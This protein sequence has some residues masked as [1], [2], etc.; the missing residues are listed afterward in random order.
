MS[1]NHNY[2]PD[3]INNQNLPPQPPQGINQNTPN[4]NINHNN[5]INNIN[6]NNNY[7]NNNYNNNNNNNNYSNYNNQ[8]NH[9]LGNEIQQPPN[10]PMIPANNLFSQGEIVQP[11]EG[12]QE[13][14]HLPKI[15]GCLDPLPDLDQNQQWWQKW[16]Q[17]QKLEL[18]NNYRIFQIQKMTNVVNSTV[19]GVIDQSGSMSDCFRWLAKEWNEQIYKKFPTSKVVTFHNFSQIE[20]KLDESPQMGTTDVEDGFKTLNS[21][22]QGPNIKDY[23]TIIF[24]SDGMD[25]NPN[26]IY[27]RLDALMNQIPR[28]KKINFITIGVGNQFPTYLAMQLRQMYHNGENTIPPVFLVYNQH[29]HENWKVTLGVVSKYL[30]HNAPVQFD[31]QVQQFPWTRPEFFAYEE[32]Y[33]FTNDMNVTSLQYGGVEIKYSEK[34]SPQ[35]VLDISRLLLSNAQLSNLRYGTNDNTKA[36][37]IVAQKITEDLK[38]KFWGKKNKKKEEKEQLLAVE[39]ELKELE[40][41]PDLK[42]KKNSDKGDSKLALKLAVGAVGA[43]VGLY[44]LAGNYGDFANIIGALNFGGLADCGCCGEICGGLC[45]T[46]TNSCECFGDIADKLTGLCNCDSCGDLFGTCFKSGSGCVQD[47]CKFVCEILG[48]AANFICGLLG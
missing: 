12:I 2:P 34:F 42:S 15:P 22:L 41:D 6:N 19:I 5:N 31:K 39:D 3:N 25:N 37:V 10:N 24:V 26:T 4:P 32:S 18:N 28:N 40:Q 33:V 7:N 27:Q 44:W 43:G 46:L 9:L 8:N 23:I 11:P 20:D 35:Q 17:Q 38:K 14:D 29:V 48:H 16:E 45:G 1:Y 13:I 30:K 21:V 47:G 36:E